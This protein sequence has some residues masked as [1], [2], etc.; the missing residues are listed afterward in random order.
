MHSG[1][2][3]APELGIKL[4]PAEHTPDRLTEAFAVIERERADALLVSA[5]AVNYANRHLIVEFAART[6]TCHV[7]IQGGRQYW[8]PHLLRR[9]LPRPI[10]PLGRIR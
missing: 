9:G 6:T 7:P 2:A 4:L 1:E 10:P 3:A 5:T 8:R